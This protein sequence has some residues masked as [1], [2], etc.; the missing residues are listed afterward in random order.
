MQQHRFDVVLAPSLDEV[1]PD[2]LAV[3]RALLAALEQTQAEGGV[4]P[5]LVQYEVGVPLKPNLLLDMTSLWPRKLQAMHCFKSQQLAQDYAKH[6]EALNVF[7]TYSLPANVTHAE[8]YRVLAPQEVL[9]AASVNQW[10]HSVLSAA[11]A[12]AEALQLQVISQDRLMARLQDQ[13]RTDSQAMREHTEALLKRVELLGDELR[14]LGIENE[15]KRIEIERLVNASAGLQAELSRVQN[16]MVHNQQEFNAAISQNQAELSQT[17]VEL[18]QTQV[19]LAQLQD[20]RQIM[21]NSNSW[22]IT[23]PLRWFVRLFSSN[24]S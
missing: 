13:W 1:H 2:H 14:Q 5:W 23:K 9:H 6:I 19:E 21:L 7:R 16:A 22:R 12:G 11:E 17:Q 8:A 10:V 3:T 20:E 18:S 15:R 24:Q 4:L